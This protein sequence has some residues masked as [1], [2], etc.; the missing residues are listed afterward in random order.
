MRQDEA[1]RRI[2]GEAF[3]LSEQEMD[4]VVDLPQGEGILITETTH[5]HVQ[6]MDSSQEEYQLFTTKPSELV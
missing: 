4:A 6:F 3:G 1:N 5:A 2:V